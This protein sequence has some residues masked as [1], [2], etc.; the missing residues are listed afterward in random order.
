M[1]RKKRAFFSFLVSILAV[2][3]ASAGQLTAPFIEQLEPVV[4]A[5]QSTVIDGRPAAYVS[6]AGRLP[7]RGLATGEIRAWMFYVAYRLDL[8]AGG[9]PRPVAFIWGGGPSGP[10]AGMDVGY[11]GPKV[12]RYGALADNPASLLPAADLVFVDPVGTGF[13]RA[14]KVEY[15]PEFFSTRGDAAAMAEFIRVWL[16]LYAAPD[17][18]VY[19]GGAS[20]GSWRAG[21][22]TEL[23]EKSGQRMSGTILISGGILVGADIPSAAEKTAFRVPAQAAA[24]L[25]FG[26]LDPSLGTDREAVLEKTTAWA[27]DVYAPALARLDNLTEDEREALARDLSRHTGYPLEK[28]DRRTLSFTQPE[29]RKNLLGDGRTLDTMDMRK[30]SAA[31]SGGNRSEGSAAA[32]YLRDVVGYRTDLA[33]AGFETGYTPV[34]AP[35]YA[36]PGRR[37]NF[38][39]GDGSETRESAAAAGLGPAGTEPWMLRSIALNPG[40]KVFVGVGL[41]DS[42]N[43]PAGNEAS[44]RIIGP[45]RAR[46]FTLRRYDC[47]HRM[48]VD[49]EAGVIPLSA[50]IRAFIAAPA[51]DSRD[52]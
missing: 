30:T 38:D 23:L 12:R 52:K 46:N 44:L 36:P 8:P 29:F 49:P 22:V 32:R 11:F 24:A 13:S 17:T 40:L 45:E 6:Q 42:M 33:Y 34:T 37:W 47:G 25:H 27:S 51:P 10:G 48:G 15:E 14:V 41:F 3:A 26:R 21:G 19:C 50:D 18:P 35:A 16:A 20:Y 4:R 7:V 43:T 9:A 5:A 28:I 39:S 1:N 2:A 31:R